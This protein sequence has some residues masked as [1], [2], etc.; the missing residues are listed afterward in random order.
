[1]LTRILTKQKQKQN[2]EYQL[3]YFHE[4]CPSGY[5]WINCSKPCLYPYYGQN[6]GHTC[7][8]EKDNCDYIIG[9]K[10]GK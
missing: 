6:C 9:C 7:S 10:S 4:D 1:M 8:C 5:F 2:D 3:I